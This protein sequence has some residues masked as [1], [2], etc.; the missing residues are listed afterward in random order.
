MAFDF[1]TPF[2]KTDPE[3]VPQFTRSFE[4]VDWIDGESIVQAA[5]TPTEE[6]FNSRFHKIIT[7]L[8]ALG[9]DARKAL[10]GAA[11]MRSSVFDLI[12]E[13]EIELERIGGAGD[14]WHTIPLVNSWVAK[15]IGGS[16]AGFPPSYFKDR[17]IVY[18]R[19]VVGDGPSP[20]PPN[21]GSLM[22]TLPAGY[23]PPAP[24]VVPVLSQQTAGSKGQAVQSKMIRLDIDHNGGVV[25]GEAY[26][27]FVALDGISFP[28]R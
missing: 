6:G 9:T 26:I 27:G 8:E 24:I 12:A 15:P 11:R 17:G 18:L 7:D 19:G 20:A 13:L 4:H 10:Q 22:F 21:N 23:R 16:P 3:L 14:P 1:Q 28:V 2:P 25:L 5:T